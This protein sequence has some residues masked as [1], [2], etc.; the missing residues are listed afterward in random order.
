[1][2]AAMRNNT[3]LWLGIRRVLKLYDQMLREV[4]EEYHLTAVEAEIIS[5]LQHNPNR[6]TAADITELRMLN[7]SSVSKAVEALIQKGILQRA[8]DKEDRRK[9]HLKLCAQAAPILAKVGIIQEQFW[10][11]IFQGFS[12]EER[13][14]YGRLS[15]RIFENADQEKERG[16]R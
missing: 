5:F 9:I 2:E 12:E 3:E 15:R 16:E 1:M 13:S 14:Q 7:K 10:E 4:C 8:P 11:V 6:D